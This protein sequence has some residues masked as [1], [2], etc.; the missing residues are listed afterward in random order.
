MVLT[1]D[2][3]YVSLAFTCPAVTSGT[4]EPSVTNK[5]SVQETIGL[6]PHFFPV[7]LKA[8]SKVTLAADYAIDWKHYKDWES[9]VRHETHQITAPV[10]FLLGVAAVLVEATV[11]DRVPKTAGPVTGIAQTLYEQLASLLPFFT[12]MLMANLEEKEDVERRQTFVSALL[13][14]ASCHSNFLDAELPP[15]EARFATDQLT[16]TILKRYIRSQFFGK[17]LITG[18]T[19][20]IRILFL[21]AGLEAFQY[22]LAVRKQLH[23]NLHFSPEDLDWCFDY[24]ETKVLV[25]HEILLPMFEEWEKDILQFGHLLETEELGDAVD[26]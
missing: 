25:H 8:S 6:S 10:D 17:R 13:N 24:L 4:G 9:S 18:P 3:Y 16:N 5:E 26:T 15:P 14:G 11:G 20:L 23:S 21:A 19:L 22:Y 1:P 7:D 2:G 12:V